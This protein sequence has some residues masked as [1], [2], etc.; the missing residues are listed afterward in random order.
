M[1]FGNR[2]FNAIINRPGMT[3]LRI[4]QLNLVPVAML[5][6]LNVKQWANFLTPQPKYII[7]IFFIHGRYGYCNISN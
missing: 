2:N 1:L 3:V 6:N 5:S 4:R 7:L